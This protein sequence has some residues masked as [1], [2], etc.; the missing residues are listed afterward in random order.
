M[1]ATH[2]SDRGCIGCRTHN[3]DIPPTFEYLNID[4][5][6]FTE[7]KANNALKQGKS[8]GPHNIP[9]QVFNN[10]ELVGPIFELC[11][12]VLMRNDKPNQWTPFNI[13]PVSK[14]RELSK[15][16]ITG[17]SASCV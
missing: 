15:T 9:S 14:E 10:C 13:I 5:E 4:D 7:A 8:I 1:A 11:K 16:E 3:K 6:P 12:I 17:A 2:E